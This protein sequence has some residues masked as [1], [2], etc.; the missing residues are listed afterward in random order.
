MVPLLQQLFLVLL[1]DCLHLHSMLQSVNT[2][3][4]RKLISQSITAAHA[5]TA[6]SICS[7]V[8]TTPTPHVVSNSLWLMGS[9]GWLFTKSRAA[10]DKEE[11]KFRKLAGTNI[12][13]WFSQSALIH[14]FLFCSQH[15]TPAR[16][17][18]LLCIFSKSLYIVS[19]SI[20]LYRSIYNLTHFVPN[21]DTRVFTPAQIR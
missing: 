7:G 21:G 17:G 9:W 5:L 2:A 20:C 10:T 18:T 4:S 6:S 15:T 14:R 1:D 13:Q 12:S 11:Q 16:S 3:R 19:L 8:M